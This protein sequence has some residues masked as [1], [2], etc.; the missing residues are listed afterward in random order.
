M[1]NTILTQNPD[2]FNEFS[3]ALRLKIR[4]TG[5][6]ICQLREGFC[7]EVTYIELG[8]DHTDLERVGFESTSPSSSYRWYNNGSALSSHS[9]DLIKFKD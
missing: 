2:D 5:P 6:V 3:T 8:S 9:H 4:E 7:I 1:E